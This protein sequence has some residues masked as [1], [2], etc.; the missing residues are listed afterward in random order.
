M[1]KVFGLLRRA[2]PD[3]AITVSLLIFRLHTTGRVGYLPL[4]ACELFPAN[5][6]KGLG[7]FDLLPGSPRYCA[8]R[9]LGKNQQRNRKVT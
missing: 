1:K 2:L 5:D 8:V 3:T 9:K 4:Y 6:S 7:I